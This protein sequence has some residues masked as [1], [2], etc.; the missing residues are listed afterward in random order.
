MEKYVCSS[1]GLKGLSS[2]DTSYHSKKIN[3]KCWSPWYLSVKLL[4]KFFINCIYTELFKKRDSMRKSL[5]SFSN[6]EL[7]R[8]K[9]NDKICLKINISS[10]MFIINSHRKYLSVLKIFELNHYW[11]LNF[12][13]AN[14][15]KIVCVIFD[16]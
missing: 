1:N 4:L 10:Y 12:R 2:T 7:C 3:W 11:Y 14:Q 8:L 6:S 13:D 5:F 9:S 16:L 15:N